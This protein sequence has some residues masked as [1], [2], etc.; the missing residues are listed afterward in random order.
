MKAILTALLAV[1]FAAA[2]VQT[3]ISVTPDSLVAGAGDVADVCVRLAGTTT[4]KGTATDIIFVLDESR[5]VGLDNFQALLDALRGLVQDTLEDS[6]DFFGGDNGRVGIVTFGFR[7]DLDLSL[8]VGTTNDVVQS[9][10]DDIS[11]A[12]DS[13]TET[14]AGI[15]TALSDFQSSSSDARTKIMIVVTDGTPTSEPQ[16]MTDAID[17]ARLAGVETFAVGIGPSIDA[18]FL[19]TLTGVDVDAGEDGSR[20]SLTDFAG[21]ADALAEFLTV[22]EALPS[23]TNAGLSLTVGAPFSP[24]SEARVRR[25]VDAT[26]DFAS[27]TSSDFVDA[28]AEFSPTITNNV[29]S[30]TGFDLGGRTVELCYEVAVTSSCD[31]NTN[32]GLVHDA[33]TYSDDQSSQ[34]V[35]ADASLDVVC[36][37]IHAECFGAD[38]DV[39]TGG[40]T[41][42]DVGQPR[43]K[44]GDLPADTRNCNNPRV[45]VDVSSEA[46]SWLQNQIKNSN[47]DLDFELT[48]NNNRD[49]RIISEICAG[50]FGHDITI[51]FYMQSCQDSPLGD[52]PKNANK[53][54]R[55]INAVATCAGTNPL[56]RRRLRAAK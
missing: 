49:A 56:G 45:F 16:S 29:V 15:T 25:A 19:K 50:N 38:A 11:F 1:P 30:I 44:F 2:Q 26:V 17:A 28:T 23:Q 41:V 35:F 5:S 14:H 52:P 51:P 39:L 3:S 13:F 8:Q 48:Q 27:T 31:A 37:P 36:D 7:A 24:G 9:A 32:G 33:I 10:I 55:C 47:T 34:P 22:I 54:S 12:A 4:L 20:I 6:L 43:Q 53:R 46:R 18:D 21:I 40:S 42:L